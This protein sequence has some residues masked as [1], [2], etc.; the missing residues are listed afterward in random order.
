MSIRSALL[1]GV[2]AIALLGLIAPAQAG[3]AA[4]PAP[5]QLEK[6]PYSGSVLVARGIRNGTIHLASPV[7]EF[8]TPPPSLNCTPAPCALPDGNASPGTTRSVDETPVAINPLNPKQVITG[9]NDYNCTNTSYRGFWTSSDGGTKWSGACGLDV[10]GAGGYGDPIVGYDLNGTVYQGGIDATGPGGASISVASSTDNG[11]NWNTPVLA[12]SINQF[13][14]KPWLQIDTNANSPTKNNLYISNTMFASNSDS[15]IYVTTSK[16]D[17]KTWTNVAASPTAVWP[18]FVNQFSD[19]A[20]G[21]DGTV[22]LTYMKCPVTGPT[23]DCGGTT[24]TMYIQKSA[25]GGNT[26]SSQVAIGTANLAPDT[27]GAFYGC[28]PNTKERTS[29]IPV[30]GID[31]S[32]GAHNGNLYVVDYNW[33]GSYMQVQVATSADGG[34]TWGAPVPV[35]PSSDTHDQFLAWLNVDA[36][37]HP[38]VTWLDRRNDKNNLSY[39]AFGTWSKPG[40]KKFNANNIQIATQASNP[41]NDG[42][43]GGFMGDYSGNAWTGKKLIATW[44]DTRNGSYS[45]DYI[46]GLKR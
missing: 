40:G 9:G 7:R 46:G 34:N 11:K 26:W 15:T 36:T 45:Q 33:T 17:G 10:Q 23:G 18:N 30:I 24:A 14:D 6:L 22:Y 5:A 44:T 13:A 31:N 38:G 12:I 20:V 8:Q 3:S 1:A 37:G 35:A 28:L 27:C 16:D 19:L 2:P 43:G 42:L 32:G 25:D 4:R 21:S 39:E 41:N 29:N